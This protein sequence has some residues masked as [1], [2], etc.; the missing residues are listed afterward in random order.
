M[1]RAVEARLNKLSQDRSDMTFVTMNLCSKMSRPDGQDLK[2]MQRVGRFLVG[3]PRKF[4]HVRSTP[5]LM[6]IG[7][8]TDSQ[9]SRSA[10][11]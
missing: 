10:G 6:R 4:I 9:D 1:F 5:L 8:E 3:R 7:Q 11:A 2:N